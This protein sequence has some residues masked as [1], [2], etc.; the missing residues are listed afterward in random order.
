V[1]GLYAG[2]VQPF[3]LDVVVPDRPSPGS[4]APLADSQLGT[5]GRRRVRVGG[6]P[7]IAVAPNL[8][9]VV[10]VARER[11]AGRAVRTSIAGIRNGLCGTWDRHDSGE[12]GEHDKC[13]GY[14]SSEQPSEPPLRTDESRA[15]RSNPR[16]A[17]CEDDTFV[18]G[19]P[20]RFT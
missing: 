13:S 7:R 12:R 14:G 1:R 9:W 6:G 3:D 17:R 20:A 15:A 11:V 4:L 19:L 10:S 5:R 2:R 16:D 8:G 18:V